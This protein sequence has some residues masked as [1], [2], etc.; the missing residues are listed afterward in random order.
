MSLVGLAVGAE[1]PRGPNGE[2]RPADAHECAIK[3]ARIVVGEIE[4]E[5]CVATGR[6]HSGNA[7]AEA[8]SETLSSEDL[9][10]IARKAAGARWR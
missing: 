5:Q 3:T 7:G 4:D 8:R 10:A 2:K 9:S 6:R 1:M